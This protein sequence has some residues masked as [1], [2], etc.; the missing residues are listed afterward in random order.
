MSIKGGIHTAHERGMRIGCTTIQLFTKNNT[1]WAAKPLSEEDIKNYK[2]LEKKSRIRP[3]VAHS[4]YLINLCARDP[5]VLKKSRRGFKDELDRCE[6]LGIPYLVFHPGAHME[7]GEQEGIERVAE[8]LNT[9]HESTQGY[10]VMSVLEVTAGQGTAIGFRFE[11][12]KKIIDALEMKER[13]GVC[14][15]TCHL[16]AA[17]YD[18]TTE[19]GYERTFDEFEDIIGLERLVVFHVNDSKREL[20]S[21]V[22]RHEH[23]GK[24]R[25]GTVAFR[26]LMNDPRF[27]KV[28]KILETPKSEDMHEDVMNLRKLRGLLPRRTRDKS[29]RSGSA[30]A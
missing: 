28:P 25:I 8:S 3:V 19:P 4:S 14:I 30:T 10:D 7:R 21:R 11:H 22:D 5:L 6:R 20:G 17:G 15:D 13:V 26:F 2:R 29:L 9:L 18:I 16:F 23:I 27:V 24:G 1:Q 12:L